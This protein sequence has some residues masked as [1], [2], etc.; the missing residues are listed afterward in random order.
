MKKDCAYISPH[1]KVFHVETETFIS[2]LEP[3]E[4]KI[5]KA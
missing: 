3:H 5:Y 2:Q 1:K 4:K